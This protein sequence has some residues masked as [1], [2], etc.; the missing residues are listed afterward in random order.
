MP[1]TSWTRLEP[2]TR[3][4]SLAEGV[5]ARVADPLWLLTRQL[6]F[7]EMAGEDTGSP[8]VSR[9]RAHFNTFNR[10]KPGA[11]GGTS[12]IATLGSASLPIERL[13]EAEPYLDPGVSLLDAAQAGQH[14]LRMLTRTAGIGDLSAYRHN[15]VQSYQLPAGVDDRL[16]AFV[17]RV[18]HGG[19]LYAALR[20]SR[21]LVDGTLPAAP[22]LGG[23]NPT[24][25]SSVAR[26][27][28]DWYRA[29]YVQTV[30]ADS[31][32]RADR[33]EY[34]ASIGAPGPGSETVLATGEY[35]SGELDWFDF[36]LQ[37]GTPSLGTSG[38][39]VQAAPDSTLVVTTLATPVTYRG[40]PLPRFWAFEDAAVDFGV[41]SAPVEDVTTSLMV[42]F[43][44]RY[45]NDHFVMPLPMPVGAVCRID[46]LV[47]VNS[48][49]EVILVPWAGSVDGV[50][51]PFRL[52][53]HTVAGGAS[54]ARSP[55]FVLFPT[56]D[57]VL[58]GPPLEEV[59]YLRDEMADLVW[60]VERTALGPGGVPVDRGRDS[61]AGQTATTPVAGIPL[62]YLE[63]AIEGRVSYRVRTD[64]PAN[65][66]PLLPPESGTPATLTPAT[67]APLDGSTPPRAWTR[68]LAEQN[69]GLPIEEVSRVGLQVTR[70]WRY[71]R[72]TDGRQLAWIARQVGAGRGPGSSG[73]RFD[74]LAP[75]QR[76]SP[77]PPSAVPSM[78]LA[79]RST[80]GQDTVLRNLTD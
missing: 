26:D 49:G 74:V 30:A 80:V 61:A 55:L 6:A 58:D 46:S 5:Q 28:Y 32:W 37:I 64:V 17:G 9:V 35:C 66:F 34:T 1:L 59:H 63:G 48:F 69:I 71:A 52:F 72:W 21:L 41:V 14:Y 29:L 36:D 78:A 57:H 22:A 8:I 77:P 43:A 18:P 39:G 16:R 7:G 75:F 73:L 33:M 56:L 2:V 54:A 40:M 42:E 51:G 13:I 15:L 76:P 47:V 38:G 65:W 10:F 23:A 11:P 25:V 60:A 20:D 70:L 45:G 31:A 19:L 68:I 62:E 44:L 50:L 79:T 27:W 53:E 4:A 3:D 24:L 12:A 67:V